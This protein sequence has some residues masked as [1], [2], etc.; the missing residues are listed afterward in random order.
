MALPGESLSRQNPLGTNTPLMPSML[1]ARFFLSL[2]RNRRPPPHLL[3]LHVHKLTTKKI[4][5][6]HPLQ[7]KLQMRLIRRETPLQH[8]SAL[9]KIR[10]SDH[11]RRIEHVN[12]Q[13]GSVSDR[14][15]EKRHT[16]CK[17]DMRDECGIAG[18]GRGVWVAT[19]GGCEGVVDGML[20]VW[21]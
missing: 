9:Q 5:I 10:K 7:Q 3:S 8:G 20:G 18:C 14:V 12:L 21:L 16:L 1:T 15:S 17:D 13:K 2:H 6:T 4:E 19:V 11:M